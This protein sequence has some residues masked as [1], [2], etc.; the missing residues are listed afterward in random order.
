MDSG[1]DWPIS[2]LGAEGTSNIITLY[3]KWVQG[4]DGT[5]Q[6]G[7]Y[8]R[9]RLGRGRLCP[10]ALSA[11]RA[12]SRRG[13]PPL[14]LPHGGARSRAPLRA[15]GSRAREPLPAAAAA[16]PWPSGAEPRTEPAH[17]R[18]V[19]AECGELKMGGDGRER[20]GFEL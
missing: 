6:S 14:A 13:A 16:C 3:Q 2:E 18:E 10:A 5:W 17:G 1:S 9:A 19:A 12:P 8:Q 20:G 15:F 11:P 7:S 4:W